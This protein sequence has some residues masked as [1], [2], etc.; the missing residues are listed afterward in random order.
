[1][2]NPSLIA[3]AGL[4][5]HLSDFDDIIDVRSPS[6]YAED[7]LPG[8]VN[9]PVLD[10]EQ[11]AE[12]G[13]LDKQS[14]SFEAKKRGAAYISEKIAFYLSN[15]FRHKDRHWKPLIYCWRGG[16]RSGAMAHV[17]AKVGWHVSQLDGGYKAYR[18]HVLEEIPRLTGAFE[19]RVICGPTGTGKSRLLHSLA[20]AGGQVL[21]LEGLAKHKGS[22]LGGLPAEPQPSQKSFESALWDTLRHCDPARVVFVESE[23]KKVG[24]LRVPDCLMHAMRQ[25][26]C[27]MLSMSRDERIKLLLEEYDHFTNDTSLLCSNLDKLTRF[28]GHSKIA[29]WRV[30]SQEGKTA[31]LVGEL[32]DLHYD[33]AYLKSIQRNFLQLNSAHQIELPDCAMESF[34]RVSGDLLFDPRNEHGHEVRRVESVDGGPEQHALE[35]VPS[36]HTQ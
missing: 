10:D 4:I 14:S 13:T 9:C 12:I 21:D 18:R 34:A 35:I 5:E 22:V 16:N 25:S 8:A 32:L 1:M 17:L 20:S 6:E 28:F 7:H 31:Q 2:K 36:D 24:N 29:E 26:P 30:M 15:H 11:R 23:S 33:P 3:I 27:I 19:Y